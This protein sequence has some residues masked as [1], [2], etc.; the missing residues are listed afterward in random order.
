[1]FLNAIFFLGPYPSVGQAC[2][3]S[4]YFFFRLQIKMQLKMLGIIISAVE[5]GQ[6]VHV[7]RGRFVLYP[8]RST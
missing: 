2:I 6:C 3:A 8:L 4:V 7:Q 5:K 1:M